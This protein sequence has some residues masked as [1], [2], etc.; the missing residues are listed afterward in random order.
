MLLRRQVVQMLVSQYA[1]L[2]HNFLLAESF[3]L[4]DDLSD[5][6]LLHE[7]ECLPA[8]HI[9]SHEL[10]LGGRLFRHALDMCLGPDDG[11]AAVFC[12]AR[13]EFSL[14][15]HEGLFEFVFERVSCELFYLFWSR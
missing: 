14:V 10:L 13:L 15:L 5:V 1:W 12:I 7:E 2:I 11:F 3:P 4:H 8:H 6:S 9:H